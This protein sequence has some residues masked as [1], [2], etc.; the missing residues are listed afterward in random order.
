MRW[1]H[2]LVLLAA[3]V[4]PACAQADGADLDIPSF[5]SLQSKATETVNVRLGGLAL[6]FASHFLDSNDPDQAQ[7]REI[8]SQLHSVQV[9][10]FEFDSDGAYSQADVEA[11]RKQL[12]SPKWTPIV[13]VREGHDGDNVD[14]FMCIENEKP[15][16]FT[17]ISSEPRELTIVNVSGPIDLERL[18]ELGG[19]LGI[20]KTGT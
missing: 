8:L 11:V 5:A 16:G 17:I 6:R 12:V 4:L 10:S 9:R 3:A 1:R 2:T 14:I 7:A 19:H 18:K 20:P 13:Q 15:V